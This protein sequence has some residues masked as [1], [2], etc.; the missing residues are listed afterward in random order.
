MGVLRRPYIVIALYANI[1]R[2]SADRQSRYRRGIFWTLIAVRP[3]SP[4]Q[5]TLR[6]RRPPQWLRKEVGREGEVRHSCVAASLNFLK[7]PIPVTKSNYQ[8]AT[9][10]RR[11]DRRNQTTAALAVVA[12]CSRPS[13]K[14]SLP[15]ITHLVASAKLPHSQPKPTTLPAFNAVA[16]ASTPS[17]PHY[18][19]MTAVSANVNT[20]HRS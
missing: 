4:S 20:Q 14:S 17:S 3:S 5:P 11:W 18:G 16:E 13:V 19:T 1:I 9:I 6:S 8:L 2:S 15:L 10:R 12:H 7:E